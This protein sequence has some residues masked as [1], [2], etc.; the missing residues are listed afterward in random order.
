MSQKY[1]ILPTTTHYD[2][3]NNITKE[4]TLYSPK[5]LTH[6]MLLLGGHIPFLHQVLQQFSLQASV[7]MS[8]H[9]VSKYFADTKA[10]SYITQLTSPTS[11]GTMLRIYQNC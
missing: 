6:S 10:A 3:K 1:K 11:L 2:C 8:L 9:L 4:T 5:F 7:P